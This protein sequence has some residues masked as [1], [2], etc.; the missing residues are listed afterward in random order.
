MH[1]LLQNIIENEGIE[2]LSPEEKATFDEW[3]KILTSDGLTRE[4]I[5][6]FCE[7]QIAT[8]DKIFQ[9]RGRDR[10]ND[11]FLA[12]LHGVYSNLLQAINGPIK[13]KAQLEESLKQ[14]LDT[15]GTS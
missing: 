2:S 3:N 6:E 15:D 13:R 8:I 4:Q 5:I 11:S 7:M 10:S 12:D 14:R 1:V 9:N